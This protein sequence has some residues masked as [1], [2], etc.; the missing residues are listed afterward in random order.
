M[1]RERSGAQTVCFY[2]RVFKDE[3]YIA[4]QQLT[5]CYSR[6]LTTGG[7]IDCDPGYYSSLVGSSGG[8]TYCPKG[9]F[10]N[11]SG[12]AT[13]TYCP[14]GRYGDRST[15]TRGQ[16]GDECAGLC[17][18]GHYGDEAGAT[19]RQC[20]GPCPIG[21]YSR[22]GALECKLCPEGRY[23]DVA[24]SGIVGYTTPVCTGECWGA[25]RGSVCC[26]E[27]EGSCGPPPPPTPAPSPSSAPSLPSSTTPSTQ[28]GSSLAMP[29]AIGIAVAITFL[30]GAF[31][32]F[33]SS[34][35]DATRAAVR[36]AE[37]QEQEAE[38][39]AEVKAKDE[40][41][42]DDK[43]HEANERNDMAAPAKPKEVRQAATVSTASLP[44]VAQSGF[45]SHGLAA[46]SRGGITS[47]G[48]GLGANSIFDAKPAPQA[49][50]RGGPGTLST[51][52]SGGASMGLQGGL[53]A[54]SL[55][56]Q[57]LG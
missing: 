10:A 7:C 25:P 29:A 15:E 16:V 33:A 32:L 9:K 11:E 57:G 51:G 43:N 8:C 26:P 40:D 6:F 5:E 41:C 28:S 42:R 22:P 55:R 30:F 34:R 38:V 47:P 31:V 35:G 18:E 14:M 12:S 52:F 21:S 48:A 37:E 2:A 49:A 56:A 44:S 23:G 46:M 4:C 50:W 13:C 45:G 17:A 54:A 3:S 1:L 19:S 53:A 36:A 39:V 20:A 27:I 24:G